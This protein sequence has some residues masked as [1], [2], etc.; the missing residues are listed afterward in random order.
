M[1]DAAG[2]LEMQAAIET[3]NVDESVGRYCV[4]LAVATRDHPDVLTGSSPRGSLGL[5]LAAR[6]WAVIRGR[7]YVIPEDINTLVP[8]TLSRRLLLKPEAELRGPTAQS[9]LEDILQNTPL[10]LGSLNS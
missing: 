2:V 3:V 6:A 10:E 1:T 4:D 8:L 7:D 9:I 5:V